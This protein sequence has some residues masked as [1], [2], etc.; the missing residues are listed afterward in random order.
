MLALLVTSMAML[1]S[2]AFAPLFPFLGAGQPAMMALLKERA[3]T[4]GAGII[5]TVSELATASRFSYLTRGLHS[6]FWVF[7][8]LH[9]AVVLAQFEVQVLALALEIVSAE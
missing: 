6:E 4:I 2:K 1:Q 7:L 8:Y 5:L 9:L 3:K